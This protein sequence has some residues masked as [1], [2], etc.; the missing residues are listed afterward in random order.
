[1]F[2][3]PSRFTVVD[4]FTGKVNLMKKSVSGFAAQAQ[5]DF[6]K[7]GQGAFELGRTAGKVG[8]IAAAPL[9][10]ATKAAAD[11]EDKMSNVATLIDT[12]KESIGD[13]GNELLVL[14]KRLPVSIDDLTSSLY[15]VRSAGIPASKAMNTLEESSRLAVAG[16]S[17]ASEATNITT[18]AINAFKKEGLT[19]AQTT[20]ILFKTVKYGKTTVSEMSQAFGATAGTVQSAGVKLA[21]F[22]A[23][24]AALT[25]VGTPAAQA[26]NQ[27]RAS[28][29][30]LQKPTA[31]MAKIYKKLGV[32]SEKE[33]ISRE[34]SL[35]G[36]F[37][38]VNKAG[39]EMG[40][41]LA[42]AWSSTEAAAAVT[43]LTG[44][45]NKA[46][47][48]TLKDMTTGT[49]ALSEAFD[50]QKGKSKA[51]LMLFKNNFQSLAITIGNA[52]LPVLNSLIE[53]VTP[54]IQGIGGWISRNK[55]LT[56]TIVFAAA[57]FSGLSLAISAGAFIM[58]TFQK[59]MAIGRIAM[60]AFN[61]VMS[62]NPIGA[63]VIAVTALV[64][65]VY[66]LS[67][68]FSSVS[69]AESVA[70]DVRERALD[71]TIDQRVEVI[72]LF[73]ALRNT[74]AGTDAYAATLKKIDAIQPGL[75][76]KYNLQAG[77]LKNINA[78]EKEL[79]ANIMKRAE[80]EA[81]AEL[82]K[83]SIKKGE[84]IKQGNESPFWAKAV[85]LITGNKYTENFA[86][87]VSLSEEQNRQ[88]IL[89]KQ[90][91]QDQLDPTLNPELAKS[92]STAREVSKS[93]IDMN[94]N[95][96]GLPDGATADAQVT[97]TKTNGMNVPKLTSTT[98]K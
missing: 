6:R 81:R 83:E 88:K 25:T 44:A 71:K 31:E 1:M 59:A 63:V 74:K 4:Q 78:A 97:K 19:A 93:Q 23:A 5:R 8:L 52:L 75:T 57:A 16:L 18:S 60:A 45:T 39:S 38:A 20:D 84:L 36:A 24:T 35:V 54:L 14:S 28:I 37:T 92:K 72:Q 51:Q 13:M 58:G 49:N 95:I 50:K 7:A 34:G 90:I 29:V 69:T 67:K 33:L 12:N 85:S 46:Y 53:T 41:N 73:N 77:A 9:A 11:F 22:S 94:L 48:D 27:I 79:T 91:A 80:A 89:T 10:L 42:K 43:S 56:K 40:L 26:Q 15:D 65:V 64:G 55:G 3:I 66:A 62:M 87:A 2:V 70:N 47:T 68:A 30:A 96:N 21:D 86:N 61:L 17:T 76:E 98:G 82:L 32:A